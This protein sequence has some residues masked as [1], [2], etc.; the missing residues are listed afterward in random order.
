MPPPP[1][2]SSEK[3][4]VDTWWPD[5][6]GKS[7]PLPVYQHPTTTLDGSAVSQLLGT[8]LLGD[9]LVP[10]HRGLETKLAGTRLDGVH[11]IFFPM[12]VFTAGCMCIYAAGRVS[13]S[14]PG[15]ITIFA[16]GVVLA[17]FHYFQ[18][19]HGSRSWLPSFHR[20]VELWLELDPHSLYFNLLPTLLF[21]E[22]MRLRTQLLS[23]CFPQAIVLGCFGTLLSGGALAAVA[24]YV[25][26]FGWSWPV[27]LVF[28]STLSAI[29]PGTGAAL[30]STYGVS[31]RL[32]VLLQGEGLISCGVA[33]TIFSLGLKLAQGADSTLPAVTIFLLNTSLGAICLGGIAGVLLIWIL[34]F[35]VEEHTSRSS[36]IPVVTCVCC[37][38]GVFQFAESCFSTSGV[39]AV[40][41]AG[42]SLA[43]KVWTRVVSGVSTKTVW[44]VVEFVACTFAFALAGLI[45]GSTFLRQGSPIRPADAA[46]LLAIFCLGALV[47]SAVVVGLWAPLNAVGSFVRKQEM[48]V[49]AWGGLRGGVGVTLAIITA[50]EPSLEQEARCRL[51]F[52][53]LG[54]VTLS[55]ASGA[56]FPAVLRSLHLVDGEAA[57]QRSIALVRK[58]VAEHALAAFEQARAGHG[59]IRFEGV[60]REMLERMAPL[61]QHVLQ[62]HD[63]QVP[64]PLR[65]DSSE[66][67]RRERAYRE[68]FLQ[69]VQ[70]HYLLAISE[71]VLPRKSRV[72]RVLLHSTEDALNST[73]RALGDWYFIEQQIQG[74]NMTRLKYETVVGKWPV[75]LLPGIRSF[76]VFQQGVSIVYA[77]LSFVQAHQL[78]QREVPQ[79]FNGGT[80]TDAHVVQLVHQESEE[81][82]A[83][84]RSFLHNVQVQE[85][86]NPGNVVALTKCKMLARRLLQ[87]RMDEYG[88]LRRRGIVSESNFQAL[89]ED[90]L[91]EVQRLTSGAVADLS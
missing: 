89:A 11:M 30:L 23:R 61:S 77:A 34:G 47:R 9:P 24:H 45:F 18:V 63:A 67:L 17:A 29:G 27:C 50:L 85:V 13:T 25:L 44:E 2:Q 28:A 68:V 73:S 87:S 22:A 52:F 6:G 4:T 38:Y 53:T 15:S 88:E 40:V 90:V 59:D 91:A 86:G 81:Q 16:F 32:A 7:E 14:A 31:P 20:S 33:V 39:I 75:R 82:C 43:D 66:V 49:I 56:A 78:T 8:D 57:R 64:Q 71:G 12:L 10:T 3:Q 76:G 55:A 58:Q 41:V 70:H 19:G 72:A 84:A 54:L 65:E 42:I 5:A 26:P 69:S 35:C 83:R 80:A 62:F 46:W 36:M 37:C 79:Y 60:S 1:G 21:A 48:A 74:W 51:S